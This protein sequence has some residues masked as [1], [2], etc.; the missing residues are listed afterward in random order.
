MPE[1]DKDPKDAE[2]VTPPTIKENPSA[3]GVVA[4]TEEDATPPDRE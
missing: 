2:A 4:S 1:D 3:T